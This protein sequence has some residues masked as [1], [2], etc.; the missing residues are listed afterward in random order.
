M[1]TRRWIAGTAAGALLLVGGVVAGPVASFAQGQTASPTIQQQS[2][3]SQQQTGPSQGAENE[4]SPN[5]HGSIQVPENT[6]SQS[7]ADESAALQHLAKITQDQARQAALQANP[8]TAVKQAEL[9]DEN[10]SLIYDV[11]LPNGMDVKVDAGNGQVL[12]T[13]KADA[14]EPNGQE[15]GSETGDRDSIQQQ[16]GTQESGTPGQSGPASPVQ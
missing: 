9:G 6:Q 10:G 13:E 11:E 4:Q 8:G 1:N 16:S 7:E 15:N 2:G 5:L 12:A 14:G 3:Q